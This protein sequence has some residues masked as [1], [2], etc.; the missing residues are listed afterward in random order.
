MNKIRLS[1]Y[2]VTIAGFLCSPGSVMALLLCC[3]EHC[4]SLYSVLNV[5]CRGEVVKDKVRRLDNDKG[6]LHWRPQSHVDGR[7]TDGR[8]VRR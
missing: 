6:T 5:P 8:A 1:G 7:V 2:Y 3:I 4:S